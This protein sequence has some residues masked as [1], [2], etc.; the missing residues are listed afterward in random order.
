[1]PLSPQQPIDI[2]WQALSEGVLSDSLLSA[3]AQYPAS[4]LHQLAAPSSTSHDSATDASDPCMLSSGVD[5]WQQL[6]RSVLA[7]PG[8]F[9]RLALQRQVDP[10]LAALLPGGSIM[11][12]DSADSSKSTNT[13][14]GGVSGGGGGSE[15]ASSSGGSGV[16]GDASI[17]HNDPDSSL[18][19]GM[20]DPT[21]SSRTHV[22]AWTSAMRD[23]ASLE[24]QRAV[25]EGVQ[26]YFVAYLLPQHLA[27][28]RDP[29]ACV[30]KFCSLL[31]LLQQVN[32]YQPSQ[33]LL[34][35]LEQI[36]QK[37]S[38]APQPT[39]VTGSRRQQPTASA[40]DLSFA[41]DMQALELHTLMSFLHGCTECRPSAQ[42]V[43]SLSARAALIASGMSMGTLVDLA[44][45]MEHWKTE[46]PA[47]EQHRLLLL[48]QMRSR[49]SNSI[50][51]GEVSPSLE[52]QVSCVASSAASF[53]TQPRLQ[54][55]G[56]LQQLRLLWLQQQALGSYG[57]VRQL[58]SDAAAWDMMLDGTAGSLQ[59][60]PKEQV[61][62]LGKLLPFRVLQNTTPQEQHACKVTQSWLSAFAASATALSRTREKPDSGTVRKVAGAVL[63]LEDVFEVSDAWL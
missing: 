22:E 38:P 63:A 24:G 29:G 17:S 41:S 15:S 50:A 45:M 37:E 62:Q 18:S 2:I 48:A 16:L 51:S 42:M 20:Q 31:S 1:M 59:R 56:P 58:L 61:L 25:P 46:F 53:L 23:F 4:R 30:H 26:E 12:F 49:L 39:I 7:Q 14:G 21:E 57:A 55:L 44:Y 43:R 40:T 3:F 8:A 34:D 6:V 9:P 5:A 33:Q 35:K 52:L 27:N 47:S 54:M 60:M 28:I 10:W 32:T 11:S 13:G 36:L 19:G